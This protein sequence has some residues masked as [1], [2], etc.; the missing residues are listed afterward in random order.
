VLT[1]KGSPRPGPLDVGPSEEGTGR[2]AFERCRGSLKDGLTRNHWNTLWTIVVYWLTWLQVA[3]NRVDV[4]M[5]RCSQGISQGSCVGTES[6][7]QGSRTSRWECDL[8]GRN[9]GD[10]QAEHPAGSRRTRNPARDAPPS[11]WARGPPR[12][13]G[14]S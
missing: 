10:E 8:R 12:E 13:P 1:R 14:L 4:D 6:K 11:G 9:G 2:T 5:G 7:H 3:S